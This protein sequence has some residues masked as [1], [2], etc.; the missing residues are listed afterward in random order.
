MKTYNELL[1][2]SHTNTHKELLCEDWAKEGPFNK[3]IKSLKRKI[4][5]GG[6]PYGFTVT[7]PADF[8]GELIVDTPAG[9]LRLNITIGVR[10]GHTLT[11]EK[12][13]VQ[14]HNQKIKSFDD[15]ALI[16]A[17]PKFQSEITKNKRRNF[18]TDVE[19]DNERYVVGGKT[20]TA[21]LSI[22]DA[23]LPKTLKAEPAPTKPK[24]R[25][26]SEPKPAKSGLSSAKAGDVASPEKVARKA[27]RTALAMTPPSPALIP[28]STDKPELVPT[29][30]PKDGKKLNDAQKCA[31]ILWGG[32]MYL[33]VDH[34][35][36]GRGDMG[37]I[38]EAGADLLRLGP[39]N[40]EYEAIIEWLGGGAFFRGTHALTKE[41]YNK[42]MVSAQTK[43]KK[44]IR[45]YKTGLN[46]VIK[47]N[48]RFGSWATKPGMYKNS[49]N[50]EESIVLDA[51]CPV[52]FTGDLADKHEIIVNFKDVVKYGQG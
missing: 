26:K 46:G 4:V 10:G 5:I 3:Y 48:D 44:P 40:E 39:N 37:A 11:V 25:F 47:P 23:A 13:G 1:L 30:A 19:Y 42:I 36:S 14:F 35:P 20:N 43:L 50:N 2:E 18:R 29:A 45:V 41:L 51:G 34:L 33:N 9:E 12:D 16:L 52:I 22:G 38:K 28:N 8:V 31:V 7:K 17:K 32:L 49:G 6:D 15:I 24:P 27:K 21:K